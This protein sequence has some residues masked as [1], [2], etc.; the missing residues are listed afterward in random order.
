M[1][2][3][4]RRT[5]R[6][7]ASAAFA[8]LSVGCTTS[9]VYQ[10][11]VAHPPVEGVVK[12]VSNQETI[13]PADS[14]VDAAA[15]RT[16]EHSEGV[17]FAA[18]HSVQP[19]VDAGN[20]DCCGQNSCQ[21]ACGRG[22]GRGCNGKHGD[23]DWE[24]LRTDH[25]WPEQYNYESRR[26]VN[27]P[28]HDQIAAGHATANTLFDAHFEAKAESRTMLSDAGKSRLSY[29]ARRKP[30]VVPSVFVQT[31]YDPA[32]D[33]LRLQ[34]VKAFLAT[35]S[36]NPINWNVVAVDSTPTGLYGQEGIY[37][38][39]KMIGPRQGMNVPTPFYERIL[40][41]NFFLG[42]GGGQAVSGGS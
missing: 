2:G 37:S 29:L 3:F 27:Q 36:V 4:V 1:N 40:K 28:L 11:T 38:I 23:H 35:V 8:L 6:R 32:L 26:R 21:N 7:A 25:C 13:M 12:K 22:C 18:P 20:G 30:Y 41:N 42:Q 16:P 15:A 24:Q 10:P 17:A 9:H 5:A 19:V 39:N 33:E 31:T 14:V 34:N